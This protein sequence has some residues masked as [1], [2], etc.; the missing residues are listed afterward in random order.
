MTTPV[1]KFGAAT[2]PTVSIPAT[3]TAAPTPSAPAQGAGTAT[4]AGKASAKK[5]D[6]GLSAGAIVIASLAA[7]LVLTCIAW[8]VARRSAYEPHWL[9]TL[10]HAMAEA[11]FRA[12]AT[13]SEFTDWVR[14]GH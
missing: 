5:G 8:G 2:T 4:P 10:R 13:W 11:G 3:A 9:L 7:L 6:S 14:L 1:E 12:S